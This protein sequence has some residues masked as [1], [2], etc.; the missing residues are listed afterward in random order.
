[1][2]KESSIQTKI[3]NDLRYLGKYCTCTK[4]MRTSDNG[5]PDIYFT[6]KLTGSV[7]IETKRIIGKTSEVQKNKIKKIKSCGTKV[8]L[9]HSWKEWLSIKSKL[10]MNKDNIKNAHN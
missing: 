2:E 1:M 5:I 8:F 10:K 9:C 6:T 3:L 7:F 4:I